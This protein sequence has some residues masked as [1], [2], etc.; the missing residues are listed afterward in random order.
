[1]H[2]RFRQ[3][4]TDGGFRGTEGAPRGESVAESDLVVVQSPGRP[5]CG[6]WAGALAYLCGIETGHG[7]AQAKGRQ[8]K[9]R[10]SFIIVETPVQEPPHARTNRVPGH[11]FR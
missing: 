11:H 6:F 9:V 10:T 2:F 1:V 8:D 7:L 4:T 3:S 5:A